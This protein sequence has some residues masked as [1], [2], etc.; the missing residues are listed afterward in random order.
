VFLV[1]VAVTSC[2]TDPYINSFDSVSWQNDLNG[3]SG[4]R[5]NQ[6]ELIMDDQEALLGWTEP[7]ITGYLGSPDYLELYVRNQKFLIYFLEPTLDCGPDGKEN[8]LRMY[9]RMDALGQSNEISLR[10]R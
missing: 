7:K 8:P 1:A 5:L 3:C 4:H 6:L 9:V 10:N 2:Q